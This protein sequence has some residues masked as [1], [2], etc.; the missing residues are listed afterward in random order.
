MRLST[1]IK[2][3][4]QYGINVERKSSRVIEVYT[5]GGIVDECHNVTEAIQSVHDFLMGEKNEDSQSDKRSEN[6][7]MVRT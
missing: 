6:V 5:D 7:Q 4:K 3:A 1:I 2:F